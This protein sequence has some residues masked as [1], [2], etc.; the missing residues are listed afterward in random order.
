[1]KR[2]FPILLSICCILTFVLPALADDDDGAK[3]EVS[4][5]TVCVGIDKN[6]LD[7]SRLPRP[8]YRE[9]EAFMVP[10]R[11]IAEALGYHASWD[12]ETGTITVDDDYIQKATLHNGTAEVVFESHLKA[13]DMGRTIDNTV[14]T[15][16]HNGYT[17]VPLEFFTEFLNDVSESEGMILISPSMCELTA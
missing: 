5:F 1:M 12:A 2:F 14:P 16:I 7:L 13:I 3:N 15:V 9:G 6:E 11:L 4:T 8:P 17:Y 10:L